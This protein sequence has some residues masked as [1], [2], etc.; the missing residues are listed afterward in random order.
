M[1]ESRISS[2]ATEKNYRDGNN[3][4]HKQSR[5]P[6][7]WRDTLKNASNGT[8]NLQTRKWSNFTKVSHPCLDDH[9]FK[10]EE[11]ESVGESSEVCSQ[12][13]LKC[14][15]LGRIERPDILWSVHKIAR[16][17]TKW[18]QACDK[19]VARLIFHMHHTND[20]RQYC[21]VGNT[22]QHCR[23][24]L[25]QDSD[26][27]GD[28][29]NSK[30]TSGR[31]LCIFGSRTFVLVSWMCQKQASV[32]HIYRES[33]VISLDAGQRM[34]G[35]LALDIWDIAIEYYEQPKTIFNPNILPTRKLVQFL[36]PKPRPNMS[37]EK[38]RLIN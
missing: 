5:C 21:H 2:G 10:Q 8:V 22:A 25:F 15:Y 35:L 6:T 30:S 18:T 14:S 3:L 31:I 20:Y 36:I 19:R 33:E 23:L 24:E 16:R 37:R 1:F 11:L 26:F 7:T 4:S 38:R 13:V 9:Q 34:D 12:I 27:A 29:D 28:L 32:S 17:V